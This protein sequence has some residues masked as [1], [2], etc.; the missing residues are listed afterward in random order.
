MIEADCGRD[1]AMLVA[2]QLVVFLKRSG[3][4]AQLSEVL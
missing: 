1:I 4:Q 3:S 2:K